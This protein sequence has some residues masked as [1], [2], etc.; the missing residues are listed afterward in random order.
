MAGHG[1]A[2]EPIRAGEL[3]IDV[4][5]IRQQAV[6]GAIVGR[7]RLGGPCGALATVD[8]DRLKEHEIGHQGTQAEGERA[9]DVSWQGRNVKARRFRTGAEI[10]RAHS[11]PVRRGGEGGEE[12]DQD[13]A[14]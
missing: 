14:S 10:F 1:I 7:S 3:R 2:G 4:G 6:D 13:Q 8:L 12:E 11:Q 9:R 5:R